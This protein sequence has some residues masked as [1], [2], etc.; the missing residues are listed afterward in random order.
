MTIEP[1]RVKAD[2][3]YFV[4][5]IGITYLASLAILPIWFFQ[6]S[7]SVLAPTVQAGLEIVVLPAVLCVFSAVTYRKK[8]F[9]ASWIPYLIVP[10]SVLVGVCIGYFNWG[11]STGRF[12]EPDA[13]TIHLTK[14]FLVL[15][16]SSGFIMW[17]VVHL[18][19]RVLRSGSGRPR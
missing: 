5:S 6:P 1:A 17:S 7:G 3:R 10:I 13:E 9:S 12:L 2:L 11:I 8:G 16:G 19:L 18:S 15:S 4:Y 14:W